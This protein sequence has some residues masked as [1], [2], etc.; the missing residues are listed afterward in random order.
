[1]RADYWQKQVDEPLFPDILWS[2]PENKSGSGKLAII[3][4]N[5]NAFSAP[6]IAY[7][8]A[9]QSGAGALQVLLPDAIRK[10]VKHILPDAGYAVSNPSGSFAGKA[11]DELIRISSWSDAVLVAGDLGRNSETAILLE[12]YVQIYTGLVVITKDA[13]DYFIETP[14][15]VVDREHTVL[16]MTL[17]QLQ[18]VFIATPSI[19]PITYSM[20]VGA[21]AEALH[22]YTLEHQTAIVVLHGNLVY[23][24]H[25][26]QVV[27]TKADSSNPPDDNWRVRTAARAAVFWM[28]APATPLK[29]VASSL[30]TPGKP[31]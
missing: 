23:I 25:G 7:D 10:T 3:G 28:Q 24:A 22:E 16:V 9:L 19:T 5:A 4:G 17:A 31:E 13:V 6:G 29:A 21:L 15:L 14:S 26:G 20:S 11:L 27:T 1:M 12:K 18:R 2:R 8:A 30:V